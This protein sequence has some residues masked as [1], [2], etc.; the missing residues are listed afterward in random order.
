MNHSLIKKALDMRKQA[1]APYSKYYVGAAVE[2]DSGHIIGGCNIESSSY[3]LTCCA[4]RVALFSS[5]AQDYFLPG[6]YVQNF[7]GIFLL[8]PT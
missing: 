8:S 1:H 7:H 4:E 3:S 5:L 2:T 6:F